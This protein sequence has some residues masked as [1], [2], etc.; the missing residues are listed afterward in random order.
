MAFGRTPFRTRSKPDAA[1]TQSLNSPACYLHVVLVSIN[2][3]ARPRGRRRRT[4]RRAP[5][6][7]FS[8]NTGLLFCGRL[9]T[10]RL[11]YGCLQL[12]LGV[13]HRVQQG[14]VLA[15]SRIRGLLQQ[16]LHVDDGVMNC[17]NMSFFSSIIMPLRVPTILVQGQELRHARGPLVLEQLSRT[18]NVMSK[19]VR[20]FLLAFQNFGVLDVEGVVGLCGKSTRESTSR[21]W[22]ARNLISAQAWYLLELASDRARQPVDGLGNRHVDPLRH[23]IF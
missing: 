13:D 6:T 23:I 11:Q 7:R 22:R 9:G 10:E 20:D 19:P 4:C 8:F 17:G 12:G 14:V 21:R 2:H 1:P 3:G 15:L 18:L 5:Q 16:L